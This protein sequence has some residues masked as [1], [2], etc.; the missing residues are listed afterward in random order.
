MALVF[1]FSLTALAVSAFSFLFFLS[2]LK[3]RTGRDRILAEFREEIDFMIRELNEVTV[4][5]EV[6]VEERVKKL[7]A[8]LEDA[9]RRVEI[10][11]R[12]IAVFDRETGRR[13]TETAVLDELSRPAAAQEDR[14]AAYARL[15]KRFT[16]PVLAETGEAAAVPP[17]GDGVYLSPDL[18]RGPAGGAEAA[19]VPPGNAVPT[20]APVPQA[21]PEIPVIRRGARQITPKPKPLPVQAVELYRA[22][23]SSSLIASKLG[24]TVT[25][26]EL[27]IAVAKRAGDGRGS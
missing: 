16:A 20:P 5:D 25:E 18:F 23:L 13:D 21:A 22:G 8:L 17:G 2:Y 6:L 11:E 7:R 4:R 24:V 10:F 15:G 3:R 14:A 9:D 26:V 19:G 12:R 27:A 1:I